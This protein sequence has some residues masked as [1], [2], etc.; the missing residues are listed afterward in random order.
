MESPR[1]TFWIEVVWP[2]TLLWVLL[3]I[4]PGR[5]LPLGLILSAGPTVSV[6]FLG[7]W[8]ARNKWT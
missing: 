8:W 5:S 3:V 1:A 4:S 7:F 2:V 6:V